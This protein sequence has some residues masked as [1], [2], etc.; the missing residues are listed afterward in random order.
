MGERPGLCKPGFLAKH[1]NGRWGR[2]M[3][4]MFHRPVNLLVCCWC[5]LVRQRFLA[6]LRCDYRR[7][8]RGFLEACADQWKPA[9]LKHNRFALEKKILPHFGAYRVC[10]IQR[11]DI[12]AWHRNYAGAPSSA[13]RHLAVLSSLMRHAELVGL[14]APGSNPC[15]GL[16]R[17]QSQFKASYLD[18]GG[19]TRLSAGL[20]AAAAEQPEFVSFVRFLCLTGCRRGEAQS[21][22]WSML[23][24]GRA[25]LPDS[26]TGPKTIWLGKPAQKLLS[27]MPR[28]GEHVFADDTGALRVG[29]IDTFWR[30]LRSSVDLA[31]LR[32]HD[33]RHSFA[34][35]AINGGV[36]LRTVG[37]L[38]GHSDLGST[39]GYAHLNEA[40]VKAASARVGRTL[41]QLMQPAPKKPPYIRDPYLAF[42]RSKQPMAAFC[43]DR[44]LDR[45][46]FH[47]GLIEWRQ[48][49]REAK[50]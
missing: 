44:S 43:Q 1:A 29:Q 33:L 25:I 47:K 49:E 13:N 4:W 46:V 19:W 3:R 36:D 14:R 6:G 24:A 11:S 34:S 40:P 21:L 48:S 9:T 12:V 37:G 16:R 27:A 39:A 23:E 50:A 30:G 45:V 26:K 28:K 15:Q 31:H 8:R 18:A 35:V 10:R 32:L 20:R 7:S 42:T 41:D 5:S 2:L 17:H 22:T 38:L